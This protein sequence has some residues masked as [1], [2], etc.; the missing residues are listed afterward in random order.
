MTSSR[1]LVRTSA[2]AGTGCSVL[3]TTDPGDRGAAAVDSPGA[4]HLVVRVDATGE[5]VAVHRIRAAGA[6][7]PLEARA[8]FEVDALDPL[9]PSL[10]E[11]ELSAAEQVAPA[12]PAVAELVC[13]GLIGHLLLTGNRWLVGRVGVGLADG[14][15][16]AGS[17]WDLA[18]AHH[19]APPRYRVRPRRPWD[20][21]AL[22][23]P[24]RTAA[25]PLM[26][27]LLR[28]GAWVCG[29][30]AHDADRDR[31]EFLVLL[32]LNQADGS[33]LR[34]FLGGGG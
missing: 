21:Q 18:L 31:A 15:R 10:I 9:R 16:A 3:L 24:R 14:G 33:R 29:P 23:W 4:E 32:D 28:L 26:V 2:T 12:G 25:P 22:R 11:V 7:R 1:V 20:P 30:P 17:A 13:T 34:Y 19:L 27:S 5:V 6:G 8:G